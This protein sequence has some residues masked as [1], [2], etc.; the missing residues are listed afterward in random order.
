MGSH[1][2]SRKLEDGDPLSSN[3]RADGLTILLP[4]DTLWTDLIRLMAIAADWAG[5]SRDRAARFWNAA[6]DASETSPTGGAGSP[7]GAASGSPTIAP[8]HP[9]TPAMVVARM[10]VLAMALA[11]AASP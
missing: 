6:S 10:T 9:A 8:S 4:I 1:E 5:A 11:A 2:P 7:A 3:L